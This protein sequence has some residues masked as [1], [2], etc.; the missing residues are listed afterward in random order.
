MIKIWQKT[1]HSF[2]RG[3]YEDVVTF[4]VT[5]PG[6]YNFGPIK[7]G[8]MISFKKSALGDK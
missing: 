2:G 3:R 7:H 5:T 4:R 8:N 6:K 1:I